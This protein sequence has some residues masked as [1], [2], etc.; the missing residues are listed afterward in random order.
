MRKYTIMWTLEGPGGKI[1]APNNPSPV[2]AEDLNGVLKQLAG[3]IPA[4]GFGLRVVGVY[5]T[6]E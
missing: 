6:E 5:I 2:E 3:N 1:H 4:L